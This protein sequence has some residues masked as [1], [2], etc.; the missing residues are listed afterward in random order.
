MVLSQVLQTN[1]QLA[2]ICV[3]FIRDVLSSNMKFRLAVLDLNRARRAVT[4]DKPNCENLH[5]NFGL[6]SISLTSM[7][8]KALNLAKL[9]GMI[10]S[11]CSE[12]GVVENRIRCPESDS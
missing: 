7:T 8:L 3:Y 11:R 2:F 5:V 6:T 1:A 4:L 9:L 12:V 10:Q